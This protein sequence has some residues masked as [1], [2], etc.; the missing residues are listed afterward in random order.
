MKYKDY[1]EVLGVPRNASAEEI[2]KAYRR[3]A[4]KYHP[5]VNKS[6]G[7]TERFKEINEANEVLGNPEKRRRYDDLGANW[8]G[9]QDFTPPPGYEYARPDFGRGA[10]GGGFRFEGGGPGAGAFSDFFETLFGGAGFSPRGGGR[11]V[12]MDDFESDM[13]APSGGADQ[14]AEVVVTLEEAFQGMTKKITLQQEEPDARGRLVR[15]TRSYEVRIPAGVGDGARIRLAGQGARSP[16]GGAAGDL[17]LLVRIAPHRLFQV[18]GRDLELDLPLAP[19]E[20]ALGAVV[21]LPSPAGLLELKIPAGTS[22]GRRLRLRGKGLP[23]Q[24]GQPQGDLYAVVK[25]VVPPEPGGRERALYEELARVS[26]FK[27]RMW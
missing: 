14:E 6:A 16:L 1:Y 10:P 15:R 18:A 21:N 8:Q 3:L 27:P 17:Y 11:R 24:G 22:S 4:R 23:A 2:K 20:A 7:T 9:G 25:L 12:T 5:D 26:A 13:G 19:W